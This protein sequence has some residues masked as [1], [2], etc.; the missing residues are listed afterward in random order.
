MCE[1][2]PVACM[3][4]WLT[5]LNRGIWCA[6]SSYWSSRVLPFSLN[7]FKL[8]NQFDMCKGINL[9][10]SLLASSKL[11]SHLPCITVCVGNGLVWTLMSNYRPR[12]LSLDGCEGLTGS[13][14]D[15]MMGGRKQ[16]K[17]KNLLNV[18]LSTSFSFKND[19]SS[20]LLSSCRSKWA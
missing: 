1:P 11:N 15:R 9:I 8:E 3:C 7:C 5:S 16:N 10:F 12:T 19:I 4:F 14:R 6:L 2:A 18:V 17:Q 20:Y 13:A